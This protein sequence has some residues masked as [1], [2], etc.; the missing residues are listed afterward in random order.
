VV[1]EVT[2]AQVCT[3][4]RDNLRTFHGLTIPESSSVLRNKLSS[5]V[6]D[7]INGTDDGR[8]KTLSIGGIGRVLEAGR[9]TEVFTCGTTTVDVPLPRCDLVRPRPYSK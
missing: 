8:S 5:N 1:V 4:L 6:V 3:S 9:Q 2:S 7:A